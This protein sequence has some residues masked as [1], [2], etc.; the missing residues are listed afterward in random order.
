MDKGRRTDECKTEVV[1]QTSEQSILCLEEQCSNN[2]SPKLALFS[3]NVLLVSVE[4]FFILRS[5]ARTSCH[6]AG[7]H[8]KTFEAEDIG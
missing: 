8:F 1:E 4:P 7:S 6:L 5:L 3:D 2:L